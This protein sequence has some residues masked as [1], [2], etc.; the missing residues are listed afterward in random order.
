VI[1]PNV[2]AVLVLGFCIAYALLGLL[3]H[4]A[5]QAAER[6]RL[7]AEHDDQGDAA[8]PG[9]HWDGT[10][11]IPVLLLVEYRRDQRDR[12]GGG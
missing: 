3:G 11:R 9:R 10:G 2:P 4:V 5:E 12:L 6:D 1:D 8:E 7:A